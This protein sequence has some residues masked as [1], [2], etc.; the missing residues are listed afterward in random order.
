MNNNKMNKQAF[1]SLLIW[2]LV[3]FPLAQLGYGFYQVQFAG[4]IFYYGPEPAKAVV[5]TLGLWAMSFLFVVLSVRHLKRWLK[6]NLQPMRRRLGLTA[7]FYALLHMLAYTVLILGFEFSE[8]AAD[9]QKRPYILVGAL[10]IVLMLPL[11]LTSTKGWQ[12]RLKRKWKTLH[13]LIYPVAV[14]VLIHL[15]WQV[16]AGFLLASTMTL[17]VLAIFVLKFLP[18]KLAHRKTS[19]NL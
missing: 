14:L 12:R 4:D 1:L 5:H 18:S 11:A 3:F 19:S 6:I 9:I 7:F 15:W 17:I 8:L 13:L 2:L 10:A 16:R